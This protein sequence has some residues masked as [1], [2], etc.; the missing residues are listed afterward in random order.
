MAEAVAAATP[1]DAPADAA[2]AAAVAPDAPKKKTWF[3][4]ESNPTIMNNFVAKMGFPVDSYRFT[5]VFSTEDWAL[6][7]VPSPCLG[8]L[9]LY[10]IKPTTEAFRAEER[11]RIEAEGQV[12][13][14]DVYY[15]KQTV[16]NACGTVGLLHACGNIAAKV[17]PSEGSYLENFLAITKVRAGGGGFAQVQGTHH[18]V[19]CSSPTRIPT[20]TCRP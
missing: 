7:M 4:L 20:I 16:G 15:M 13:D 1:P 2:A 11:A 3:P 17:P 8:V 14:E 5:D 10:P 19:R 12:V 9:F 18:D 6:E